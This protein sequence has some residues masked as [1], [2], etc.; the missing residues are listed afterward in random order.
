[1]TTQNE[2]LRALLDDARDWLHDSDDHDSLTEKELKSL[3]DR[4]DTALAE[5]VEVH[6]SSM[7]DVV[8]LLENERDE[9]RAEIERLRKVM[10]ERWYECHDGSEESCCKNH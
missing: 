7:T 5:S 1:M 4:I 9:A 6:L 3:R 10:D 8:T 2:R